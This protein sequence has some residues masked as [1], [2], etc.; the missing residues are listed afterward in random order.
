M[1][2][3][4]QSD[5]PARQALT[6]AVDRAIANGSPVV[7][8][9]PAKVYTTFPDEILVYL[10]RNGEALVTA[11]IQGK[12][13]YVAVTRDGYRTDYPYQYNGPA[14]NDT[15]VFWDN[16]EWFTQGFKAQVIKAVNARKGL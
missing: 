13:S 11:N 1:N 4:N 3:P 2:Y 10:H 8:N 6:R 16:P 15:R 12:R 5:N 7:V 9:V 14:S